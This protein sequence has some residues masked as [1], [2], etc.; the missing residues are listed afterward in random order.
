LEEPLLPEEADPQGDTEE[1]VEDEEG[2]ESVDDETQE[3]HLPSWLVADRQLKLP[4]HIVVTVT[5][6]A[7]T[8]TL[9]IVAPNLGDVLNLVGCATGTVIAFILPALFSFRLNGYSHTALFLLI[10]GGLVGLVGTVF[11]TQQ[12]IVDAGR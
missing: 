4:Q 1:A 8:T 10:V 7:I 11:S 3:E 6:W 2:D 12:L 9:A 5:L